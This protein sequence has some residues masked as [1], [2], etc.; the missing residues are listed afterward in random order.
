MFSLF[1]SRSERSLQDFDD[2]LETYLSSS[3]KYRGLLRTGSIV[4]LDKDNRVY[5]FLKFLVSQC[6]LNVGIVHLTDARRATEAVRDLGV[7]NIKGVVIDSAMLGDSMNGDSFQNWLT[8]E[9]PKVPVWAVNC[10][11]ERSRWIRSQTSHISV[12]GE[13]ESL[14]N[15]ALAIG[16]P[17]E[18]REM[19]AQYTA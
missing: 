11:P 13:Q 3:R 6:G 4:L 16:F 19:A 17:E 8:T 9:H 12:I 18:C 2:G 5:D 1:S 15:V 7:D 10:V 14:A